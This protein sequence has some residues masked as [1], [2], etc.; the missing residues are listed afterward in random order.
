MI[1]T[2]EADVPSPDL[3]QHLGRLDGMQK[4]STDIN[5]ATVPSVTYLKREHVIKKIDIF[6]DLCSIYLSIYLSTL[7]LPYSFFTTSFYRFNKKKEKELIVISL[8]VFV[9]EDRGPARYEAGVPGEPQNNLQDED[10]QH[11]ALSEAHLAQLSVLV[12]DDLVRRSV[13]IILLATSKGLF[14]A[15]MTRNLRKVYICRLFYSN[16]KI[17]HMTECL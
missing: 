7:L 11:A 1:G 2:R 14:Q 4:K 3:P 16:S 9:E 6:T 5:M 15:G 17:C 8:L 10:K 13:A 12:F